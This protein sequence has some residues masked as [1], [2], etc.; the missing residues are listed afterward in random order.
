[1][2]FNKDGLERFGAV[3]ASHV[4]EDKVPDWSRW[5]H[6]ATMCTWRRSGRSRSAEAG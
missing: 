2:G 3:A 1:M 4:G 6:P 5:W